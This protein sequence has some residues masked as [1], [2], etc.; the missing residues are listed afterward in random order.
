VG[1]VEDARGTR[2]MMEIEEEGSEGT[3]EERRRR[4]A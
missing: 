4:E 2:G 3:R 1:I